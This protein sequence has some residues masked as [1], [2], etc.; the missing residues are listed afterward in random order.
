MMPYHLEL[1]LS[2]KKPKTEK[3]AN[4]DD[5]INKVY[6]VSCFTNLISDKSLKFAKIYKKTAHLER[7]PFTNCA[8]TIF[9]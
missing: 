4:K 5:R 7:L 9:E 6:F 2:M 3:T 8:F 1:V